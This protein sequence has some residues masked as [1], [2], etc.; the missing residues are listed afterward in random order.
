MHNLL[1]CGS[2]TENTDGA[3]SGTLRPL[4]GPREVSEDRFFGRAS[5]KVLKSMVNEVRCVFNP[6]VAISSQERDGYEEHR[7][8]ISATR[9]A[10]TIGLGRTLSEQLVRRPR[11]GSPARKRSPI[12]F[13]R[14]RVSRRSDTERRLGAFRTRFG[15]KYALRDLPRVTSWRWETVS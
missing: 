8:G 14:L 5:K 10:R 2:L 1:T 9:R 6:S 4:R 11:A 13:M 15:P 7:L 3:S 12:G